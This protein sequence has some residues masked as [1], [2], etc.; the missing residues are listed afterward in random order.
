[1]TDELPGD[2]QAH[3]DLLGRLR[4]ATNRFDPVPEAALLGARSK[5]AHL[6]LDAELAELIFDSA[7]VAR[8]LASVRAETRSARQ[9]A[10]D[11]GEL[12]IEL[13]IVDQGDRRLLVGQCLPATS[14]T[15]SVRRQDDAQPG[16]RRV[17]TTRFTT[18]DLGRFTA[19][20]PPGLLSLRCE[21]PG[22][23]LVAETPWVDL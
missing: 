17:T 12:Q 20:V 9:L 23:G 14:L 15:V 6:R 4:A 19:E 21:W 5:L 10:F 22:T 3:E 18:D 13:E 1:M 8:E 7:D 2:E 11:A 16:S